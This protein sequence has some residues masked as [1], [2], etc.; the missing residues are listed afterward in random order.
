[1]NEK[2]LAEEYSY[3]D[4]AGVSANMPRI[5]TIDFNNPDRFIYSTDLQN[6]VLKLPD[7]FSICDQFLYTPDA[8]IWLFRETNRLTVIKRWEEMKVP[9]WSSVSMGFRVAGC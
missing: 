6:G 8:A 7:S 9:L 4:Y 5:S 1:M 3:S 2:Q